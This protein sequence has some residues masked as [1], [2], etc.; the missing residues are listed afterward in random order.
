MVSVDG[1]ELNTEAVVDRDGGWLDL[2][3]LMER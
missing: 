1:R 2:M 3:D